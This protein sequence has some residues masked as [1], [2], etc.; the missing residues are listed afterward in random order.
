VKVKP[1]S[2]ASVSADMPID[3]AAVRARAKA[4]RDTDRRRGDD[5]GDDARAVTGDDEKDDFLK[6][7]DEMGADADDVFAKHATPI[8]GIALCDAFIDEDTARALEA[9][10]MR[11]PASSWTSKTRGRRVHNV[12][13]ASPSAPYRDE[14]AMKTPT[15]AKRLM[16]HVFRRGG[17]ANAPNHVLVNEYEANAGVAPHSDGECYDKDV[18]ILTLRGRAMIEFWP[19]DD[20][21][22]G[23]DEP[24]MSLV[25]EPRSLLMY[26]GDAYR[27]RHGIRETE[28]DVVT[29]ATANARAL[30]LEV[31]DVIK[32]NPLGRVSVVFV[33]KK[34]AE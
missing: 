4:S 9:R 17:T 2:S 13:G 1:E 12:G 5:D 31:G 26:R 25:L 27:L 33:R 14:D 16:E 30:G 20:G 10:L 34:R 11:E 19:S 21:E 32:R 6:D 18:A 29:R 8:A 22:G 7:Y 15:Y 23:A 24:V 3:F 28:S